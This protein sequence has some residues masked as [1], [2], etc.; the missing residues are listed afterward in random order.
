MTI[1]AVE[2]IRQIRDEH[3]KILRNKSFAER[4]DF[5]TRESQALQ[6]RLAQLRREMKKE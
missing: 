5:Y 4:R 1:R 3:A 2:L 6:G